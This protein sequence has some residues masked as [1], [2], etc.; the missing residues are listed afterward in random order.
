[1]KKQNLILTL[2][3]AVLVLFACK[4]PKEFLD[5]LE[6]S[7]NPLESHAGK[8]EVT[9]DGTFPVKYFTKNMILTVTP[10]LKSKT[11]DATFVGEPVSYQGE[12]IKGND[13]A[14]SYKMGGKYSQKVV[15]TYVPE[16]ESSELWLEV[17]AKIKD[18]VYTIP[19]VKVADGVNITPLLVALQPGEVAAKI[20]KDEFQRVIE[21]RQEAEI[22]FLIQQSEIRKSE[23]KSETVVSLTK[24][25]D[26]ANKAANLEMKGLEVA[27]YASPDGGIELNEKLANK[28]DKESVKFIDKE[29]KKLKATVTIDSKF[30]AQDWDGF[31]KLMEGS[32]IQDKEVILRVLSMYSDSEQRET[33]IKNLSAAY[34]SIADD[35]LPQLRRSKMTLLIDVIGRSDAEIDSLAKINAEVL[36]VEEL[37]YAG[38]LVTD[39]ASKEAVY[40]KVTEVY[41]SEYRGFN[42]LG[43]VKYEQGDVAA[44]GRCFA[45]ALELAP[46]NAP[47]NF[48][49]GLVALANGDDATAEEFFGNAGGV[50]DALNYVNGAIAIKKADYKKAVTLFGNAKMN[51]AALAKIMT[52]D[53]A[54]ARSILDGVE[55]PTATTNYLLAI[56]G[57]RTNDRELAKVNLEKAVAADAK[58]KEKAVKD[59]EFMEF[60]KDEAFAAIVK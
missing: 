55:K 14:I 26:E 5:N 34:K 40:T 8:V 48:N 16:M 18:K 38:T 52:K 23:V 39:L 25:I 32:N 59:V 35:I 19:A 51:N 28:R 24:R 58:L 21:E 1:M 57:A 36:S 13:D 22:K 4:P 53:Y 29:L 3:L 10:V 12:K 33:E 42:N 45:K 43:V 7:V 27:S 30:T 6:V 47:V 20:E 11:S 2:V 54:G 37:L 31:Q 15:F 44:A 41:P 56:V 9:I 50:G 60:M 49:S 17:E 46:K